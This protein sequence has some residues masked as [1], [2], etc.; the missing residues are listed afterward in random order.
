MRIFVF[1]IAVFIAFGVYADSPQDAFN[2]FDILKPLPK[3][4]KD[5]ILDDRD[6]LDMDKKTRA[7]LEEQSKAEIADY[8]LHTVDCVH[9]CEP[10]KDHMYFQTSQNDHHILDYHIAYKSVE[11]GYAARIN[12]LIFSDVEKAKLG[13]RMIL[14][15]WGTVI[16]DDQIN[17]TYTGKKY[18]DFC[19]TGSNRDNL[20]KILSLYVLFDR[21]WVRIDLASNP[22]EYKL[23]PEL[24][25]Q[26]AEAVLNKIRKGLGEKFEVAN[27]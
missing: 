2:P 21:F 26:W 18:G 10:H 19:I 16:M 27:Q 6:I 8:I 17:R 23:T 4:F 25:D 24:L 14:S 9:Q 3:E 12:Y 11:H 15:N 20:D 1:I 13:A 22:D 5:K 7:A